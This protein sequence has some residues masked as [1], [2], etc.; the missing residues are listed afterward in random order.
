MTS[1]ERPPELNEKMEKILDLR[2]LAKYEEAIINAENLANNYP[3]IASVF[4]LL[5]SLYFELDRYEEAALAY[6][7]ATEL[8]PK[9]EMASLGLFHSLWQLERNDDAFEEM[10]R[11]MAISASD[12]YTELVKKFT[13][14]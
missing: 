4:G 3:E 13:N 10:K 8:S 7:K 5:A 1:I 12:E 6:Q 9:S 14:G 11:F 2:K